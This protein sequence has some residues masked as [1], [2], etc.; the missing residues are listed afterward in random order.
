LCKK[1]DFGPRK[2]FKNFMRQL[3][4]FRSFL[5]LIMLMTEALGKVKGREAAANLLSWDD[6]EEV[7]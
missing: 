6:K 5:E 4:S 2:I 7:S 3:C 1:A